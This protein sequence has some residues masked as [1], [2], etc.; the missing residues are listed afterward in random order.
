MLSAGA[1]LATGPPAAP[2]RRAPRAGLKDLPDAQ[3]HR[4]RREAVTAKTSKADRQKQFE[5]R[6]HREPPP[7]G[8]REE[9]DRPLETLPAQMD[10]K[11]PAA[12][13]GQMDW[14]APAASSATQAATGPAGGPGPGVGSAK[15]S[16]QPSKASA[17]AAQ[18][19]G[20]TRSTLAG[21]GSSDEDEGDD[22]DGVLWEPAF[23]TVPAA[24]HLV[25]AAAAAEAARAI[26]LHLR[27]Q[28]LAPSRH[29]KFLLGLPELARHLNGLDRTRV[30]EAVLVLRQ[31]LTAGPIAQKPVQQLID[32]G[33]APR[34]V[35]ALQLA[36]AQIAG[37]AQA[38]QAA[39]APQVAQRAHPGPVQARGRG[40]ASVGAAVGALLAGEPGRLLSELCWA[41]NLLTSIES[42]NARSA[43][44][45]LVD[46]GLVPLLLRATALLL[47][48]PLA[49][50]PAAPVPPT[51]APMPPTVHGA[52][53]G[54][55]PGAGAGAGDGGRGEEAKGAFSDGRD[56]AAL[57]L[58]LAEHRRRDAL[59]S[60]LLTLANLLADHWRVQ[61][62]FLQASVLVPL[63][64]LGPALARLPDCFP[65][66]LFL[67]VNLTRRWPETAEG[68]EPPWE[69][70]RPLVQ[71][72]PLALA[73][74]ARLVGHAQGHAGRRHSSEA[75]ALERHPPGCAADGAREEA[76]GRESER[77]REDARE[78]VSC[79]A[80]LVNNLCDRVGDDG[81]DGDERLQEIVQTGFVPPLIAL[82]SRDNA[83]GQA[84]LTDRGRLEGVHALGTVCAGTR[85]HTA[86][87][88][89]SGGVPVFVDA[90]RPGSTRQRRIKAL[91]ALSNIAFDSAHHV[92]RLQEANAYPLAL[93]F[94]DDAVSPLE[95]RR[96]V[97][98]LLAETARRAKPE[99]L[100][101]IFL[102]SAATVPAVTAQL[103]APDSIAREQA[104]CALRR[105]FRALSADP[106]DEA[107][108]EADGD[109]RAGAAKEVARPPAPSR[110]LRSGAEGRAARAAQFE[111]ALELFEEA[112]GRALIEALEQ[113][114]PSELADAANEFFSDFLQDEPTPSPFH[115]D[116]GFGS[117]ITGGATA[118]S[119]APATFPFGS[120]ADP[121]EAAPSALRGHAS[122]T[123]DAGHHRARREAGGGAGDGMDLEAL[124][125]RPPPSARPATAMPAYP[126]K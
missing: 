54:S 121:P 13:P 98:W 19:A 108:A 5:K 14:K 125:P 55:G 71:F 34:L 90:L 119:G 47:A 17:S 1:G 75:G 2:P 64:A 96:E 49:P 27:S 4:R 89:G 6:R 123:A 110:A 11:A 85:Q 84:L 24:S 91:W 126:K 18:A 82:L 40:P 38:A 88:V 104:L 60:I 100:A 41:F 113:S 69:R 3:H 72:L 35:L 70:W 7:A 63:L 78:C 42:T 58:E 50:P 32:R 48:L 36:C 52:G 86:L 87:V 122:G 37:A 76:T 44:R 9:R 51:A 77:A 107:S 95:V 53:A 43:P 81:G 62:F 73:C 109:D 30:L 99:Q 92:A 8:H 12:R 67:L 66:L 21:A 105:L 94:L 102:L 22:P 114:E 15:P 68:K 33:F 20:A 16:A 46:A 25:N 101:Q 74:V 56:T 112:G 65:R 97:L 117:G 115:S 31:Y 45:V 26:E 39:Q 59:D 28:G 93:S 23:S 106:A 80:A 116:S 29:Q 10:C 79:F 124:T 61:A 57:E 111:R 103:A 83:A 120:E 118:S